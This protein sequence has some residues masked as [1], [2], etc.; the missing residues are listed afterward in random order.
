MELN[1]RKTR[2]IIIVGNEK[3]KIGVINGVLL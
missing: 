3:N 2:L 1:I